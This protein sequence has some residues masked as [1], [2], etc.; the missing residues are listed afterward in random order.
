MKRNPLIGVGNTLSYLS[1]GP[2]AA[3]EVQ[4]LQGRALAPRG[5]GSQ[6][7][8]LAFAG[9]GLGIVIMI[10]ITIIII[11]I[12]I[13]IIITMHIIIIMCFIVTIITMFIIIT[14]IIFS[15]IASESESESQ[16]WEWA[17]QRASE[18][19]SQPASQLASKPRP[20]FVLRSCIFMALTQSLSYCQGV[21]IP[22]HTGSPAGNSTRRISVCKI[23]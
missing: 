20:R 2:P 11:V 7:G 4:L 17:S 14:I 13:I 6:A 9:P 10:V 21:N 15:I 8:T 1:R 16:S 19:A 5:R 18:L 12:I 22:Q 3:E 23:C